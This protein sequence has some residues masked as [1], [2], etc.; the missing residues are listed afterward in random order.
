[1]S[2]TMSTESPIIDDGSTDGGG[3]RRLLL[4][5]GGAALLL[6]LGLGAYFLFLSGGGEEELAPV[7]SAA[8][9]QPVEDGKK[10]KTTK[11]DDKAP[12]KTNIKFTV[13]SDP[14]APLAAEAVI[15]P[16]PVSNDTT[17]TGTSNGSGTKSGGGSTPAPTAAPTPAPT[18]DAASTYEVT[19]RSVDLKQN[20]AVIVVEGKRYSVKVKEM[21]PSSD[22]GPF[23][24]IGVGQLSSGKDT[25][26]VVF[27]SDVT[28][29]LV[30]G[31]S[32]T[33]T[34]L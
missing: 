20:S 19:L 30:A 28:V 32:V 9:A 16:D 31:K 23:K 18:Q 11:K 14:F 7:P 13:G 5:V 33:F 1:M 21:F 12:N 2:N 22:I 6:V 10:D 25:A 34:T 29:G 24:L 17:S 3:Q 15:E 27:G 26:L 8:G 4:V